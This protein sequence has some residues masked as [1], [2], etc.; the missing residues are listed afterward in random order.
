MKGNPLITIP[1]SETVPDILHMMMRMSDILE[2]NLIDE[3]LELDHEAKVK[4]HIQN[5]MSKLKSAFSACGV[6]LQIWNSSDSRTSRD[7]QYTSFTGGQKEKILE[8]LP[9]KLRGLLHTE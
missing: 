4:K 7:Y 2:R 1:I 9:S 8:K 6:A 5:N 3:V